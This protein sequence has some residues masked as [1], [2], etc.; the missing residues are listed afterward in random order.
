MLDL[1]LGRKLEPPSFRSI[2]GKTVLLRLDA[3]I[4]QSHQYKNQVSEYPVEDG[5]NAADHILQEPES[6]TIEGTVSN[7][8]VTGAPFINAPAV[9]DRDTIVGDGKDR[10]M[11]A[12]EILLRISGRRLVRLPDMKGELVRE[13]IPSKPLMFDL[14]TKLRV[15]TDMVIEEL[16]FDFDKTTGDALPFKATCKR[17]RKVATKESTINYA[18]GVLYGAAGVE[19]Q[20]TFE[21]KGQQQ[22]KEP[23]EEHMSGIQAFAT[24]KGSIGEKSNALRIHAFDH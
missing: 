1:L 4:A 22:P 14:S 13:T 24:T 11:T 10:V 7:S 6:V 9:G 12:Y 8:P 18:I 5:L 21:D 20:T 15:F 16:T 2:D 23:T 3:C 17:I 19:D